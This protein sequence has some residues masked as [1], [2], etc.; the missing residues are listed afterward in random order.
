MHKV[1]LCTPKTVELHRMWKTHTHTY[2]CMYMTQ[3]PL[4]IWDA[5]SCSLVKWF[6]T[7]FPSKTCRARIQV[8]ITGWSSGSKT[9]VFTEPRLTMSKRQR[10]RFL[11][12][13]HCLAN[14]Q[15]RLNLV[16]DFKP[17]LAHA[18]MEKPGF[19]DQPILIPV[20]CPSGCQIQY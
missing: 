15:L 5:Q 1:N 19:I 20:S 6:S 2:R 4:V 17:I 8:E 18:Y 16:L 3:K 9:A 7:I 13:V 10:T 14:F 12:G 11:G